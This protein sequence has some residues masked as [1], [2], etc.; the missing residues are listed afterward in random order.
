MS[1]RNLLVID[2]DYFFVEE[3]DKYPLMYDWGHREIPLF[4]EGLWP[5]RASS[6][7]AKKVSLPRLSG[8]ERTWWERFRFTAKAECFIHESNVMAAHPT[9]R[10][11]GGW[12]NLYLFDAHHD[13]GYHDA[14]EI[15]RS[16]TMDCGNWSLAYLGRGATHR[17][18]Y[19]KWKH[20]A[21]EAESKAS[22]VDVFGQR[23]ER[24]FD[25]EAETFPVFSRIFICRSGAW[26][27]PWLDRQFFDF[28]ARCP[29]K[30]KIIM[31]AL[32][33]RSWSWRKTRREAFK[34]KLLM[35]KN[36]ADNLATRGR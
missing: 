5:M 14:S 27:P 1:E 3:S 9:V 13:A 12:D 19:P 22:L 30:K 4:I 29:V 10:G 11:R 20:W 21:F 6:F 28:I 8:L 23:I 18:R 15:L 26:V 33:C 24:Q 17:V 31:E 25:S 36:E 34:M 16:A 7:L 32:G 35:S 2:W